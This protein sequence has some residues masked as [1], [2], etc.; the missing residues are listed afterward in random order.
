MLLFIIVECMYIIIFI[1]LGDIV[2]GHR[3][4]GC[5]GLLAL[6]R[7]IY[8]VEE[9]REGRDSAQVGIYRSHL[10]LNCKFPTLENLKETLTKFSRIPRLSIF[11]VPIFL[12]YARSS[13]G[14]ISTRETRS[15]RL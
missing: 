2:G 10:L 5:V 13:F 7:V 12:A 14:S 4:F 3:P 6:S 11:R 15:K 8:L 1:L 9:G